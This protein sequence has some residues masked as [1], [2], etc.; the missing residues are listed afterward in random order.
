MMASM[1][2]AIAKLSFNTKRVPYQKLRAQLNTG[3]LVLFSGTTFSSRIVQLF[4]FSRWSHIGVI[5][6]LP[7]HDNKPLLW[8]LTRA[9]KLPDIHYGASLGDG[10]QL[11]SLDDKLSSYVGDV[12]IRRLRG[13]CDEAKR[14]VLLRELLADWQA[15]PY[16][17]IIQKNLSAWWRGEEATTIS[18]QGG[19]CSEFVAELYKSWQLLPSDRPSRYY[20]PQDFAQNAS[21]KLLQGRLSSAW[22]LQI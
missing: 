5:V 11:V 15:K 14:L 22:L 17:N 12:A 21:L 1:K 8:E 20:V 4:T 18:Q 16:R 9:S 19:F 10:V 2:K 3:D 7:E 13:G 6:R